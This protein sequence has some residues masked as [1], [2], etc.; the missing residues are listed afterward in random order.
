MG[1]TR[2]ESREMFE[3]HKVLS[4]EGRLRC[5][6]LSAGFAAAAVAAYLLLLL[7][8]IWY[9]SVSAVLLLQ[10]SNS[11]YTLG[12]ECNKLPHGLAYLFLA[13]ALLLPVASLPML[14]CSFKTH[15]LA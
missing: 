4:I 3:W 12:E 11:R 1:A 6:S 8:F 15:C 10:S 5:S 9:C 7:Q 14:G 2:D 13:D